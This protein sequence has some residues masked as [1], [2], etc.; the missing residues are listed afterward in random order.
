[1]AR[2]ALVRFVFHRHGDRTPIARHGARAAGFWDTTVAPPDVVASL[3]ERFP[4]SST[5]GPCAHFFQ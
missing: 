5:S 1:M 4:L 2:R 3:A